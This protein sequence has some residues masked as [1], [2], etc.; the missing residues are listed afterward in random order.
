MGASIARFVDEGH[1]VHIATLT[2]IDE[3]HPIFT[4]N[5]TEIRAET[6]KAMAIRGVKEENVIYKDMPNVLIPELPIHEVNK[7]VYEVVSEVQPDVLY[8]PFINDLHKDHRD[9]VYAAQVAAR[10]TTEF[11]KKIKEVY[12]YETL[13][14]THWNIDGIEGGFLPNVYV[15]VDGYLERK[16]DAISA[17]ESQLKPSPNARSVE[18]LR[19]LAVFRG[20]IAAMNA[21]EAFVLVR[22][23]D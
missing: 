23:L 21:A 22:K 19:A 8:I 1:D 5:K 14:E 15:D 9:I 4:P 11:G 7:V 17:Y 20:S 3:D 6:K 13:S 18:A 12:M 2:S 10:T 16:L